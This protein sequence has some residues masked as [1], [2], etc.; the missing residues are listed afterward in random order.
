MIHV[1]DEEWNA[2]VE[3]LMRRRRI[4]NAVRCWLGLIAVAVLAGGFFWLVVGMG[5]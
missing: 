5:K 3:R 2:N 1:T 4:K